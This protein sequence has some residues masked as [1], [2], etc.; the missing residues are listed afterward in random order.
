MVED[1][2]CGCVADKP[3]AT[4]TLSCHG[5]ESSLWPLCAV[6]MFS[7]CLSGFLHS[8][9]IGVNVDMNLCLTSVIDWLPV[10]GI[11]N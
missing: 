11:D 9:K 4:V 1:S 8:P 10:Q 6:C 2:H 5:I 3:A 7:P